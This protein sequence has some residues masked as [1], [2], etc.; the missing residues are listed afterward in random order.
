[1]SHPF[2]PERDAERV[3]TPSPPIER[4]LEAVRDGRARDAEAM[5][6][7]FSALAGAELSVAC[8]LGDDARV[9][10]FLAADPEAATRPRRDGDWPALLYACASWRHERGH[11]DEANLARV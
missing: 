9:A 8:V 2:A 1:M 7:R 11:D 6:E 10:A 4:F 5:L 3:H